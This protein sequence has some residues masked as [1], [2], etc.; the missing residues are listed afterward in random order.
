MANGRGARLHALAQLHAALGHIAIHRR[1][2][3]SALL[4]QI[5]LPQLARCC[6]QPCG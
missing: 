4:I 5:G 3:R 2:N 6:L 1:H